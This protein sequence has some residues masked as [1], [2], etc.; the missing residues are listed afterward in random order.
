MV[1]QFVKGTIVPAAP[2]L[3]VVDGALVLGLPV[4]LLPP[5]VLAILALVG[6]DKEMPEAGGM[7]TAVEEPEVT[8]VGAEEDT[9]PVTVD[10]NTT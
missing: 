4:T 10:V 5:L 9:L 7:T 3:G 8:V 2:L 1:A 6:T